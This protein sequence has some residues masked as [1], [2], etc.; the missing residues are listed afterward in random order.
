[1]ISII[2]TAFALTACANAGVGAFLLLRYRSER[3][4]S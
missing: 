2:L 4:A 3:R 1:M